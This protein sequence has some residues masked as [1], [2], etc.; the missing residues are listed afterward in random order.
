MIYTLFKKEWTELFLRYQGLKKMTARIPFPFLLLTLILFATSCSETNRLYS[1]FS[2]FYMLDVMFLIGYANAFIALLFYGS[3][4]STAVLFQWNDYDFLTAMPISFRQ[5]IAAKLLFVYST[6]LY[7]GT[8]IF[9]PTLLLLLLK[10]EVSFLVFL[11]LVVTLLLTPIFPLFL[12]SLLGISLAYL[13]RFLKKKELFI[14]I[15]SMILLIF[16]M[17]FTTSISTSSVP[18][19][20]ILNMKRNIFDFMPWAPMIIEIY[21][22][23]I[24]NF[25]G[26][27]ALS[28]GILLVYM[29]IL[30]KNL[31]GVHFI[32]E[33]THV[34]RGKRRLRHR[35]H[36]PLGCL[37]KKE[38]R[39]L[40]SL[41]IYAVN[42]LYTLLFSLLVSVLVSL[43]Q[44]I[45][46]A[47][48]YNPV[49]FA[50]L[51]LLL[52]QFL[53]TGPTTC[54]SISLEGQ[55]LWILESLPF[56]V[57]QILWSKLL[58]QFLLVVPFSLLS[59]GILCLSLDT[60]FVWTVIYFLFPLLFAL[61]FSLIGLFFQL[62]FPNFHWSNPSVVVKQGLP[63]VYNVALSLFILSSMLF[64]FMKTNVKNISQ[65][66][67][68][69]ILFLLLALGI[70]FDRFL[71]RNYL[72]DEEDRTP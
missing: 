42:T 49:L 69:S 40:F 37:I 52:A 31:T 43:S 16:L 12:S 27:V 4:Y 10:G 14:T 47:V 48:A 32:L 53:S 35:P 30:E 24:Y 58:F 63:L 39:Q 19:I 56:S 1:T 57:P 18:I 22:G 17:F 41:P 60:D 62:K 64:L 34:S 9:L 26:F 13:S 70:L 7:I 65:I 8:M 71:K 21:D 51:P 15:C 2:S 66:Y 38:F 33:H 54:S 55:R 61:V 29:I 59:S 11:S 6:F 44:S 72:I 36:S 68:V 67:L 5:I 46:T 25:L 45:Q 28:L 50:S 20:A 3:F 23:S